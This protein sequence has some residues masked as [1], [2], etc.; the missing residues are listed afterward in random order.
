MYIYIFSLFFL[1]EIQESFEGWREINIFKVNNGKEKL[2][3]KLGS[4]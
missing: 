3:R 1:K 2:I 4:L